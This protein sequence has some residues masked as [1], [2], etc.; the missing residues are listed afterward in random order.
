VIRWGL[1][2]GHLS[3]FY[4]PDDT[5]VSIT[6]ATAATEDSGTGDTVPAEVAAVAVETAIAA[7]SAAEDAA[8]S[9]DDAAEVATVAA[10]AT[11]ATLA[12]LQAQLSEVRAELAR[13]SDAV[14]ENATRSVG[15]D[16]APGPIVDNPPDP[17]A[18]SETPSEIQETGAENG[19]N[20]RPRSGPR[21]F[22]PIGH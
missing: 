10:S 14:N 9:A 6:I 21:W 4:H 16:I 20:I 11:Q 1:G 22:R 8:E 15:E 19:D 12:D 2:V 13:L 18:T 7:E 17:P 3:V 5:E